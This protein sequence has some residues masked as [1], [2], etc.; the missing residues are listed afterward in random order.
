MI[1]LH[2]LLSNVETVRTVAGGKFLQN[3][4]DQV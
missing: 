4:W 3:K 1:V 2:E